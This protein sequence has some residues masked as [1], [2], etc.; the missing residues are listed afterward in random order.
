MTTA[1][2]REQFA[3]LR[4]QKGFRQEDLANALGVTNQAV[5]KW[6]SAQ[7]SPDIQLLPAIA[8]LFDVL[9]DEL[10]GYAPAS[11]SEDIF[12]TLR[13]KIDVLLK[14]EDFDVVFRIAAALHASLLSKEMTTESNAAGWGYSSNSVDD[15]GFQRCQK[16]EDSHGVLPADG[17]FRRCLCNDCTNQREIGCALRTRFWS[18]LWRICPHLSMKKRCKERVSL[19]G[20]V[21]E[22]PPPS[23]FVRLQMLLKEVPTFSNSRV[24]M[25]ESFQ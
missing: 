16:F 19:C 7:C 12:L 14:G 11:T 24:Y 8:A 4:K 25:D 5:S 23:F 9:M 10:L 22:H 2:I 18:A 3:F 20:N 1:K 13:R 17:S 6:E 15:K 21:Y